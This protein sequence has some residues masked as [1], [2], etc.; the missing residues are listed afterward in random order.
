MSSS[1]LCADE[2]FIEIYSRNFD[3]VYHMCYLIL[4]NSHDAE[5]ITQNVF[6]KLYKTDIKF[7]DLNHEK[8][9]LLLTAKN[10]SL[11][12]LKHWKN[13]MID[14]FSIKEE[15]D[16][17]KKDEVLEYLLKL[18]NEYKLVIYMHYYMGYKT[19][20]I[21]KIL[22]M[23]EATI[24]SNLLRGRQKLKDILEEEI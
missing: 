21:A 4:R 17:T 7:N 22:N 19:N 8:G 3:N 16:N 18:K 13:R 10:M 2:E 1:L 20:E 23:K 11:N 12:S 5:D 14:L 6:L 15:Q 24:R 9:W